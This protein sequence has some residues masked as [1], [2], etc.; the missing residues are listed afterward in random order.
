MNKMRKG[1]SE[2]IYE[3]IIMNFIGITKLKEKSGK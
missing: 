3:K 1:T 2:P